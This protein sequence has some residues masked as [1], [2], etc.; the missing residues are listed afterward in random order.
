MGRAVAA[1]PGIA[2]ARPA[3][4]ARRD[5]C[6]STRGPVSSTRII[7]A[8]NGRRRAAAAGAFPKSMLR[9]GRRARERGTPLSRACARFP[10]VSPRS[11]AIGAGSRR[12]RAAWRDVPAA[13]D[14]RYFGRLIEGPILL[15]T[16]AASNSLSPGG[17]AGCG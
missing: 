17:E 16:S 9:A 1:E 6:A 13:S 7:S 2:V 5:P 4:F 11:F 10:G 12:P 15:I 3:A 14:R 8:S